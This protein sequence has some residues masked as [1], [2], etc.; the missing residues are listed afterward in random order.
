MM[1]TEIHSYGLIGCNL[2]Y[3]TQLGP[4]PWYMVCFKRRKKRICNLVSHLSPPF[5]TPDWV[6]GFECPC[7][8]RRGMV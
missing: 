7:F 1:L 5:L 6:G 8:V 4:K 2:I 3:P